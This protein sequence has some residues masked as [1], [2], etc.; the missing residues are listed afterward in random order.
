VSRAPV[1]GAD[2]LILQALRAGCSSVPTIAHYARVEQLA[3]RGALNRLRTTGQVR[4]Y[5]DKRGARYIV[6]NRITKTPSRRQTS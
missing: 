6:V 2:F 5:G 4:R 1:G 3:A